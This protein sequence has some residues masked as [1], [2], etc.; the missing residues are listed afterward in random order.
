MKKDGVEVSKL[1]KFSRSVRTFK[2][3]SIHREDNFVCIVY[4][5]EVHDKLPLD[6]VNNVLIKGGILEINN[7]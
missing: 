2:V 5:N 4:D 7:K 3:V 1:Y 6:Y